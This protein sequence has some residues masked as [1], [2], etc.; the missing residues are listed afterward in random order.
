M[1]LSSSWSVLYQ[2][3][4]LAFIAT[5]CASF[6]AALYKLRF[7]P[8]FVFNHLLYATFFSLSSLII[9]LE[10]F[11]TPIASNAASCTL[12]CLVHIVIGVISD[13]R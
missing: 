4:F 10:W 5:L 3:T 6:L 1:L 13:I 8:I 7:S 9:L 2:A 11:F 12:P